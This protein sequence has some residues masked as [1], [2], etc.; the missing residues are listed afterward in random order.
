M[1]WLGY[2]SLPA[3]SWVPATGADPSRLNNAYFKSLIGN[4]WDPV[5]FGTPTWY[6]SRVGGLAMT[7]EDIA[8]IQDTALLQWAQTYANDNAL[9]LS[10]FT[11]A[12]QRVMNADRFAG[13][14]T[15]LC[16]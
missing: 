10:T 6:Y 15:S 11:S 3:G 5:N 13:P 7:N 16:A 8:I 12:W 4:Q 14:T 2:S 1:I 9:F